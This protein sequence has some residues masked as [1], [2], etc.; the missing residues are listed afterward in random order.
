MMP[1]LQPFRN[2]VLRL[3]DTLPGGLHGGGRA[4][5]GLDAHTAARIGLVQKGRRRMVA[6]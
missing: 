2:D 3:G 4:E 5:Q 1:S 6:R